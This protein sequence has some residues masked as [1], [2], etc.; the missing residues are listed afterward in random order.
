MASAMP[1]SPASGAE[2]LSRDRTNPAS[3]CYLFHVDECCL[4]LVCICAEGRLY[5]FNPKSWSAGGN[6]CDPPWGYIAESWSSHPKWLEIEGGHVIHQNYAVTNT[7]FAEM[8]ATKS[9][10]LY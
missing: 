4:P 5:E 3:G 10:M 2:L 6:G 7:P 1:T 9:M 8:Y